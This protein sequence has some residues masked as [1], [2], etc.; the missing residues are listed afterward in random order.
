MQNFQGVEYLTVPYAE[1]RLTPMGLPSIVLFFWR[2][3]ATWRK[4]K[5]LANPTKGFLRFRKTLRHIL[6]KIT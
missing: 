6:I 4:K 3:S 1:E 2:I 5:G